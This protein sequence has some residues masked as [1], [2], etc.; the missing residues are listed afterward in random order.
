MSATPQKLNGSISIGIK[1]YDVQHTDEN[2]IENYWSKFKKEEHFDYVLSNDV[3]KG[4][5]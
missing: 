3:E 4:S 5:H 2:S 1:K